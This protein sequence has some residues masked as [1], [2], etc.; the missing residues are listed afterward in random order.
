[1]LVKIEAIDEQPS[2]GQ[3][4]CSSW[5]KITPETAKTRRAV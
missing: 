1:M 3:W 5:F 2:K 4:I